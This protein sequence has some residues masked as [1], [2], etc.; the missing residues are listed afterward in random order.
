MS[1][2]HHTGNCIGPPV[3]WYNQ[4]NIAVV[5][6][7]TSTVDIDDK[8]NSIFWKQEFMWKGRESFWKNRNKGMIILVLL[9]K[10]ESFAVYPLLIAPSTLYITA[11]V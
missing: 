3:N 7:E 6:D 4:S 5:S 9:T 2:I 8:L 11:V 10:I 1:L